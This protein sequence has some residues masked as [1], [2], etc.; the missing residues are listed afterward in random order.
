MVKALKAR[1]KDEVQQRN[2]LY[3]VFSA[4]ELPAGYLGRCPRLLHCAPLVLIRIESTE[5]PLHLK[6]LLD[7]DTG[8]G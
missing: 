7:S 2:V 1:N 5:F 4:F 6:A 3:R 8:F